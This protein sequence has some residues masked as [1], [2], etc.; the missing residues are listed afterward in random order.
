M[1]K[2]T[3]AIHGGYDGDRETR[4]VATPIYQ[5]VAY[6]FDS[7]DHAA[8]LFDLEEEG[9]RYSRIANP[10]VAVLERR[11]AELEGGA[12]ALAVATGQAALYYAFANIAD[13]GASGSS[14]NIFAA[15]II[16][17]ALCGGMLVAM[18][19]AIP[20]APLASRLGN[21]PGITSGSSSSPL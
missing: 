15:A 8:A 1:R 9:Y 3:I 18:P 12:G 13:S 21:R 17:A 4:A 5:T 11:V 7:A 19:T 10:T 20:C 2:E 16:S 14:I 6:E